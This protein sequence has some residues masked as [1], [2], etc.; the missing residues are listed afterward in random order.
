MK[1]PGDWDNVAATM[2]TSGLMGMI[3][4][5]FRIV[6]NRLYGGFGQWLAIMASSIFV[7]VV[8][9]LVV[10]DTTLPPGWKYALVCGCAFVAEQVLLAFTAIASSLGS[11]PINTIRRLA[12]AFKGS[13]VK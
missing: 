13:K 7:A 12:A 6:I 2:A 4:G 8:V 10:N 3:I 11:D 1:N 5:G 9:G